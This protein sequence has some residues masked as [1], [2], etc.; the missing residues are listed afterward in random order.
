[1]RVPSL[2]PHLVS[3]KKKKKKKKEYVWYFFF[4]HDSTASVSDFIA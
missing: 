4:L 2:L 3:F 1:M